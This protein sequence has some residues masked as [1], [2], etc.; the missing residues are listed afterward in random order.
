MGG[1]RKHMCACRQTWEGSI[2]L[3][4]CRVHACPAHATTS[5]FPTMH[6]TAHTQLQEAVPTGEDGMRLVGLPG[7]LKT[8]E[9]RWSPL[10]LPCCTCVT[11]A[12]SAGGWCCCSRSEETVECSPG[13]FVAALVLVNS[14]LAGACLVHALWCAACRGGTHVLPEHCALRAFGVTL[15]LLPSCFCT[16]M[17]TFSLPPAGD[18]FHVP[19]ALHH[20]LWAGGWGAAALL[21]RCADALPGADAASPCMPCGWHFVVHR[22]CTAGCCRC[23]AVHALWPTLHHRACLAAG[24]YG[25][26][27]PCAQLEHAASHTPSC[28]PPPPLQHVTFVSGT[29]GSG[30]SAALQVRRR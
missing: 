17:L 5:A 7:H 26:R 10:A 20:G 23:I 14:R 12:V 16:L 24:R 11:N 6:A 3:P 18:Q 29:N 30:K 13:G 22:C 28:L 9:V 8:I 21:H 2:W 4:G 25:A 1:H 15:V 27:I 19:R